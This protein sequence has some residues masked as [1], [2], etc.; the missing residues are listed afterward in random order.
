MKS[1]GELLGVIESSRLEISANLTERRE[2]ILRLINQ[3]LATLS[4][5]TED[6]AGSLASLLVDEGAVL[7]HS[8]DIRKIIAEYLNVVAIEENTLGEEE[9]DF[10]ESFL[11]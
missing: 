5:S 10:L 11:K 7:G 1:A 3:R 2:E 4:D 6:T 9:K 8:E